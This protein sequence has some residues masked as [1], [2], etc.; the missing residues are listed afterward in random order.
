M[1]KK[2]GNLHPGY[3]NRIL[4]RFGGV[5]VN[6]SLSRLSPK[7]NVYMLYPHAFKRL[8]VHLFLTKVQLFYL[9]FWFMFLRKHRAAV[10][11]KEKRHMADNCQTNKHIQHKCQTV[12][13]Q[14]K[15]AEKQPCPPLMHLHASTKEGIC[16]WFLTSLQSFWRDCLFY[17]VCSKYFLKQSGFNKIPI[18]RNKYA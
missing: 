12:F 10:G 4:L 2:E 5:E 13:I 11:R 9:S 1:W 7:Q 8:E 17:H 18:Y 3:R 16:T 14:T 15:R 6:L